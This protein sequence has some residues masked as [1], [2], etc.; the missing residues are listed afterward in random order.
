ML[1]VRACWY[2]GRDY[3]NRTGSPPFLVHGGQKNLLLHFLTVW[4]TCSFHV[5]FTDILIL[6]AIYNFS[7]IMPPTTTGQEG[8]GYI[9]EN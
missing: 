7:I 1:D 2:V 6:L 3:L 4:V 5:K 8:K 9:A